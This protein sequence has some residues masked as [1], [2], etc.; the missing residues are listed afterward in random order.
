MNMDGISKCDGKKIN[1]GKRR[2]AHYPSCTPE[3]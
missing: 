1:F 3:Q 2:P